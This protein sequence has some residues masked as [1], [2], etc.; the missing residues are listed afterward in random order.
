MHLLMKYM[1]AGGSGRKETTAQTLAE[2]LNMDK[3]DLLEKVSAKKI[4]L[5]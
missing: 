4:L 1:Y 3:E 2:I 5:L